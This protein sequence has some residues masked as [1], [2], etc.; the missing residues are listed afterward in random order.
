MG[1]LM[2]R[3]ANIP[4]GVRVLAALLLGV[5]LGILLPKPGAQD[6]S[7]T[8]VSAAHIA[9]QLWLSAL[10]MTVLP[11]IFSLLTI[12]LTASSRLIGDGGS[13]ARRSLLVFALLYLVCL[14]AAVALNR[15]LIDVW[16]VSKGATD[17]FQ[18]LAGNPVQVKA[19][20]AG[21]I[22]LSVVP[23]NIFGALAA[24]SIL[25]VVVFAI[26]FG[27]AMRHLEK[28]R[29]EQLRSFIE[30]IA[31]VM[32][33]IVSWVLLIAPLG[34]F[35][36]VL[37]TAHET[38]LAIVW[39]LTGYLRH[40]TTV[41]VVMMALAYPVAVLWGRVGLARFAAAA[42]SSQLVA[43]STQ[44]SVASLPVM[45]KSSERLGIADE[46]TNVS[47]PLAVSIFRFGGPSGT[48]SVAFYAAAAAGLHPA[49]PALIGGALLALLMEFAAVGLPNQ[50]NG[51][52]INA[53]VFAAF[54]A[55]FAFLP[56]ML[57]VETIPDAVGTT[58][59][60]SMDLAATAVVDRLQR[61]R[62]HDGGRA[63]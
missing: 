31:D 49:L 34:V 43:V 35:G 19:P 26:L 39:G 44:S 55:P 14:T 51:F 53:P 20:G 1:G 40:V 4:L 32:F 27:F 48:I 23:S 17:A 56:M 54:G 58:A 57:A 3:L 10:Q 30:S 47:L 6:W 46:V 7:D 2:N 15:L 11:L 63:T 62:T 59:N 5:C 52:T 50:I 13:V 38:G 28:S 60:V 8:V 22:I 33:K 42:T 37:G 9:G 18:K 41:A 24:G 29:S 45:L 21:E 12:G 36:L 25:P 61:R 16:P